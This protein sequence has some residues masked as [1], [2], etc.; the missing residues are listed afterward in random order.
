MASPSTPTFSSIKADIRKGNLNPVYLLHGEESY[1]IDSLVEMFDKVIPEGDRDFNMHTLY[2]SQV[3]MSSVMSICHQ[4]PMMSDRQMVILKECQSASKTILGQLTPYLEN[5]NPLTVLVL[6]YRGVKF[7][8]TPILKAIKAGGGIIYESKKVYENTAPAFVDDL[9]KDFGVSIEADGVR[10]LIE[11]L[12]ADLAKISN[13]VEKLALILGKGAMIT[14]A[15][16][17]INVG[18]SREYNNRELTESISKRNFVK[19]MKIINYF[20]SNPKSNPTVVTGAV[21]FNYFSD[22]LIAQFTPDKSPSS[23]KN[24]LGLRSE[25]MASPFINGMRNFNA[26]QTIEIINLIRRFDA[27]IKGNGSRQPEYTLLEELIYKIFLA[28]GSI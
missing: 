1:F 28:K 8:S 9:A 26:W 27:Q 5:P 10:M 15:A 13:E 2:A 12:G 3:D 24:A 19:S 23:L 6:C 17:E 11:N 16:I 21:L 4:F 7:D 22:L 20:K 14:P 18:I 25:F